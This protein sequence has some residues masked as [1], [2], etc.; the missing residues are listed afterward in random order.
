MVSAELVS[1]S[2]QGGGAAS[3]FAK[4]HTLRSLANYGMRF[5]NQTRQ[6]TDVFVQIAFSEKF[7]GQS[8]VWIGDG[9]ND[10][11]L[12][13]GSDR[14]QM[15]LIQGQTLWAVSEEAAQLA[16]LRQD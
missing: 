1:G 3:A 9:V 12:L 14:I 16:V 4:I 15:R 2:K 10:G 13:H 11:I 5:V 6:A 8:S 7:N